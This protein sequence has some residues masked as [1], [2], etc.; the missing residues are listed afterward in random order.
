MEVAI[1]VLICI[2]IYQ[3][4]MFVMERKESVRRENELLNRL[5]ARDYEQ[6]ARAKITEKV[7]DKN[8]PANE[9]EEEYGIPV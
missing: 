4:V 5:M 7:Y 2:I 1:A 8:P 6:Y 9:V 3:G